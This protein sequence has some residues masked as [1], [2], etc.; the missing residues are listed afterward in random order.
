MRVQN[1][2]IGKAVRRLLADSTAVSEAV[3][4]RIYPIIAPE[5]TEFPYITYTCMS[6]TSA[7]DKDSYF[8]SQRAQMGVVVCTDKYAGGITLAT[9]VLRALAKPDGA[10]VEGID[11]D[12]IEFDSKTEDYINGT[13]AQALV[14]NLKIR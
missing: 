4:G 5:N 11:I 9:D 13:Y 12:S 2:D 14:F 10:S 1:I 8:Y 7:S 6:L 3:N